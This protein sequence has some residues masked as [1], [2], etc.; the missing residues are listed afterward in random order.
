[1]KVRGYFL[2]RLVYIMLIRMCVRGGRFVEVVNYLVE[3][4]EMNLLFLFRSF[5]MVIDGLKNCGKYDLV[6]R[7]E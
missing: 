3:M 5:D 7:I 6:K 2:N 4:I 1:M